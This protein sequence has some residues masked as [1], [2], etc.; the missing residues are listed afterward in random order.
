M[1]F[2]ELNLSQNVMSGVNDAGFTICTEVQEKVIPFAVNGRDVCVQSQTGTGKTA[3]F[4]LSLFEIMEK[5]E[6]REFAL[7]VVPTRELAAQIEKEAKL[8]GK[9]LPYNI[10]SCYGGVGYE[11]QKENLRVGTEI[12]IGTPGRLI[13]LQ[14]KGTLKLEKYHFAVID[15][16]DRM[17]D[18]GF[19]QDI[20][21]IFRALPAKDFRQIMLFS[22]TMSFKCQILA[23]DFMRN[24]V[25]IVIN[26][27]TITVDK[28]EQ[29]VYHV[30]SSNKFRLMLGILKSSENKRAIVFSN[31]RNLCEELYA[32]L[33]INGVS[34]V[35]LTGDMTQRKRDIAIDNFKKGLICVL[36]ATDIAARGIHVDNLDIVINYDIPMDAENYIHRI[37]RTARAGKEGIAYTFACE[38]FAEYLSPIEERINK[39]IPSIIACNDDY[40]EDKSVGVS[41]RSEIKGMQNQNRRDYA[42]PHKRSVKPYTEKSKHRASFVEKYHE[43]RDISHP[44][45]P[46]SL[47]H[48]HKI[49]DNTVKRKF[50]GLF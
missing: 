31:T 22:A 11:E 41:W 48:S 8:L 17:F 30:G 45:N 37:G 32:K 35:Y 29:K 42:Y 14:R 44:Q 23:S 34:A 19:Y 15:E 46:V 36:V 43:G 27:E 2:T 24:P 28:I 6:Y 1:K 18:M 38:H 39:K 13:D 7:I 3:A 40:A 47:Q 9:F 20:R 12:L 25:N 16:A 5:S 26:P 49:H 4:L 10:A 33:I 50:L 21:K